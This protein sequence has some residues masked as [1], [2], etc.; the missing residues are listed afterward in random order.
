MRLQQNVIKTGLRRINSSYSKIH[1]SDVAKKLNLQ[2]PLDVEFIIA[3]AVRDGVINA[4]LNH[5]GQ[6]LVISVNYPSCL[7][8]AI[9][10]R[11]IFTQQT[12][13]RRN[14]RRD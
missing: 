14:L 10:K 9:R 6:Y 7:I 2:N 8:N 1:F 11:K 13:Q 12:S 3:K 4:T 5:E